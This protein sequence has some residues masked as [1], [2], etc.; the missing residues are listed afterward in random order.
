[1]YYKEPMECFNKV[2]EKEKRV[3]EVKGGLTFDAQISKV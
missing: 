3:D 1:M 2:V